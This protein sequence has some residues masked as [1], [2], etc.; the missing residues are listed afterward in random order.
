M[1]VYTVAMLFFMSCSVAPRVFLV[2]SPVP[3]PL[4]HSAPVSFIVVLAMGCRARLL[5]SVSFSPLS[6]NIYSFP[7][8]IRSLICISFNLP[9]SF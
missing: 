1:R 9:I 4:T 3:A 7:L 5:K 2:G 8:L 6:H